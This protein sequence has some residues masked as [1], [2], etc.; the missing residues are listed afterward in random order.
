M[1]F[2]RSVKGCR[3]RITNE[4]IGTELEIFSLNQKTEEN[5]EKWKEHIKRIDGTRIAEQATTFKVYG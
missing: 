5:G 3:Y 1:K 2:L 4:G